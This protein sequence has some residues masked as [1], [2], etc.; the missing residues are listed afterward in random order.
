MK[1]EKEK[2]S[3]S[4]FNQ[5]KKRLNKKIKLDKI[6][7]SKDDFSI[8]DLNSIYEKALLKLIY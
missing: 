2:L 4:I 5:I 1:K 7:E 8:Y 6:V 3:F